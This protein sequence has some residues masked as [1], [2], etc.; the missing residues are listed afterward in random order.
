[1]TDQNAEIWKISHSIKRTLFGFLASA[2]IIAGLQACD[3]DGGNNAEIIGFS[4]VDELD[5][6][7]EPCL[8]YT[9]P[10]PRDGLLSRMPSSA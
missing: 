3:S 8:L 9:S 5:A 4:Y 10:S 6:V 7:Y 1:M 2:V